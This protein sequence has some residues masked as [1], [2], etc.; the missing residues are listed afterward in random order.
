[1][2]RKSLYHSIFIGIVTT[3]CSLF[4]QEAV[5]GHEVTKQELLDHYLGVTSRLPSQLE[6]TA[7]RVFF[8]K[9]YMFKT[10]PNRRSHA[11]TQDSKHD[12]FCNSLSDFIKTVY[13]TD[14]YAE[15]LSHD[16]SHF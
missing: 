16:G 2:K 14:D 9:N 15:G 6:T 13:N 4:A 7:L 5:R 1:M 3:Y 11:S 12:L 8:E 10:V